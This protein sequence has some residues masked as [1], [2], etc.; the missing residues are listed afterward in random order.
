MLSK[1]NAGDLFAD[2]SIIYEVSEHQGTLFPLSIVCRDFMTRSLR[3]FDGSH[4]PTC[5]IDRDSLYE[6]RPTCTEVHRND[7][8]LIEGLHVE[9]IEAKGSI[10][11]KNKTVVSLTNV[12]N[13]VRNTFEQRSTEYWLEKNI[14]YLKELEESL[15]LLRDVTKGVKI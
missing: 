14:Y 6:V 13:T 10:E 15:L 4:V 12:C 11:E 3:L 1:L 5:T 9:L 8:K 7:S 2:N